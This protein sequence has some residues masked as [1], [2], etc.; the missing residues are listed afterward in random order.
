MCVDCAANEMV[1]NN[2]C[3]PIPVTCG[4]LQ[5]VVNN[6]CVDCGPLQEVQNNMCVDCDLGQVITNNMCAD[7]NNTA[8]VVEAGNPQT[9]QLPTNMVTMAGSATDDGNPFP[10]NLAVNW[11]SSDSG[12]TAF[13]DASNPTTVVTFGTFGTYTLTLTADDGQLTAT[14]TVVIQVNQAPPPPNTAPVVQS[15]AISPNPVT[16]PGTANITGSVLDDGQPSNTLTYTW[17]SNPG[18][19]GFG[20][21]VSTSPTT[22]ATF[23]NSVATVSYVITLSVSDD[24]LSAMGT[25]SITV[26]PAPII[27]CGGLLLNGNTC[28]VGCNGRDLIFGDGT[29]VLHART[30]ANCGATAVAAGL[31]RMGHAIPIVGGASCAGCH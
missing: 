30:F 1:M 11:S 18:G 28:V 6:M 20:P 24:L 7:P 13:T 8:S 15:I 14:D 25:E 12:Y 3:V 23:P 31:N 5:I 21:N 2:M 4:P 16:L 22:T 9:I 27:L 17:S 10:P 26:N 19:V 29:A